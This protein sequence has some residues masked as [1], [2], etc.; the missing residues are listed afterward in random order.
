MTV[1]TNGRSEQLDPPDLDVWFPREPGRLN[2]GVP[3]HEHAVAPP[4][5]ALRCVVTTSDRAGRLADRS[6]L[7]LV[8]WN[9]HDKV[10]FVLQGDVITVTAAASSATSITTQGHLRIPLAIRRRCRIDAGT[11]LLIATRPDTRTLAICTMSAVQE[12]LLARLTAADQSN[13]PRP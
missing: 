6:V 9:P 8:D 4:E 2:P 12:M 13:G 10:R 5:P 7:Q 1:S 11:R 3:L